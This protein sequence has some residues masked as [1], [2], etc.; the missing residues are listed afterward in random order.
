MNLPFLW[1]NSR[2]V[3]EGEEI[4]G[5]MKIINLKHQKFDGQKCT[6]LFIPTFP[7]VIKV[8]SKHKRPSLGRDF[9]RPVICYGLGYL[10]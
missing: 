8:L 9:L 6:F 2:K 10:P 7:Y 3:I 5:K 1:S 4:E